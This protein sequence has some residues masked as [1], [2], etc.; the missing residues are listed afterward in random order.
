MEQMDQ[1]PLLAQSMKPKNTSTYIEQDYDEDDADFISVKRQSIRSRQKSEL[2]SEVEEN[3]RS[4]KCCSSWS[5]VTQYLYSETM[6]KPTAFKIGVFTVFLVVMVITMLKS[7][8]DSAPILY[9][10]LG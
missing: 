8:V 2:K 5:T 4:R 10:K 1:V 3:E 9:V 7:V 6:K